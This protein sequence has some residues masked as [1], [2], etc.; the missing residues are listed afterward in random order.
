[1]L[2]VLTV[3]SSASAAPPEPKVVERPYEEGPLTLEDFGVDP[4]V[5]TTRGAKL[6]ADVRYEHRYR[7]FP[8]GGGRVTAFVQSIDMQSIVLR[9]RSWIFDRQNDE[10]LAYPQGHFDIAQLLALRCKRELL[11]KLLAGENFAGVGQGEQDAVAAME[12]HIREAIKPILDGRKELHQQFDQAT[13]G[14]ADAEA[15]AAQ[16][17]KLAEQIAEV[18]K[19]VNKLQLALRRR[20][21]R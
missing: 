16:R 9:Y 13:A 12:K 6:Y 15:V 17:K 4:P 18:E 1:M 7:A 10:A 8:S 19:E 2:L 3:C 21:R 11:K 14:G 5:G 20:G